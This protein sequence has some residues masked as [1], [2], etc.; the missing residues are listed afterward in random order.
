MVCI[1]LMLAGCSTVN[2]LLLTSQTFPPKASWQEVEIVD[3]EPLCPHVNIARLSVEETGSN[4]YE[5]M[6]HHILKKAATLGSDAVVFSKPEKHVTHG[7]AYQGPLLMAGPWGMGSYYYPGWG[8]GVPYGRWGLGYG[9]G[10]LGYAGGVALPYDYT[11]SSLTG[12]AM[13]YWNREHPKC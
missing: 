7:V 4:S 5:S 9:M 12:L 8:Y 6:Q 10:G 13:R 1:G 3:K 11:T 2:T